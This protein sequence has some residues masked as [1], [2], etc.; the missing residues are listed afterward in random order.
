M[1]GDASANTTMEP[2]NERSCAACL[3]VGCRPSPPER[4]AR[5]GRESTGGGRHKLEG[6]QGASEGRG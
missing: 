1:D 4:A 2:A 5:E 6:N 3:Q